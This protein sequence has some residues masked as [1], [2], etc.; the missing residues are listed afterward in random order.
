MSLECFR[1]FQQVPAIV[2]RSRHKI[3]SKQLGKSSLFLIFFRNPMTVIHTLDFCYFLG[4]EAASSIS[5]LSNTMLAIK[6]C[7]IVLN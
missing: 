1:W 3:I 7:T 6:P 5:C 2:E 4:N